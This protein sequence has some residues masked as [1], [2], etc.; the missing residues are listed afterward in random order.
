[1]LQDHKSRDEWG[2]LENHIGSRPAESHALSGNAFTSSADPATA[3]EWGWLDDQQLSP[4]DDEPS[5]DGDTSTAVP[6]TAKAPRSNSRV[7][8]WVSISAAVAAVLVGAVAVMS[9]ADLDQTAT[10]TTTSTTAG[11]PTV[12]DNPACAGLTGGLVT[13]RRG[14]NTSIGGIV[15]SFEFAYYSD[16]DAARALSLT[17]PEAGLSL[18]GLTTG[19][20]SLPVGT[21]HCVAVTPL[22][23]TAADVH[24]VELRPD[25]SR[26][27]Y[28]QVINVRFH[29]GVHIT[30]IQKRG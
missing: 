4:A 9:R 22:S 1:M 23:E 13:D 29:D 17:G 26:F 11:M 10:T 8:S 6:I 3:A 27:D 25:R 19:I 16:R 28:L 5:D 7:L 24:I 21:R 20:A 15:A 14:D 18:D 2:W 30:N 12:S